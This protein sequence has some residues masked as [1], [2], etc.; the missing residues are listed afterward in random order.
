MGDC[1]GG[2]AA[3]HTHSTHLR[4]PHMFLITGATGNIGSGVVDLLHSH[5][6]PVRALVRDPARA[7]LLPY[8][9]ETAVGDLDDA[10]SLT[11]AL[12]GVDAVFL[13]HAGAGTAQT[14][15][16]IGAA[17]S[18]GVDRVVLLSSIGA[19]LRPTP[20]IGQTLAA[21]E[22]LMRA[23]GLDVTYLRPNTLMS[24][25]LGWAEAVREGKSVVDST[26]PGR[27][28]CVDPE[29]V[30]RVAATAL[31]EDGHSGHG[32]IL[33]GPEALTSAEQVQILS[34]VLG[35]SIDLVDTTPEQMEAEST[36]HGVPAPAA[37]AMRNLNEM[38]RTSRAG[39]LSDDVENLTGT[40]PRT[41]QQWCERHADSFR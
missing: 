8:G 40:P 36:A 3:A 34:E 2:Y 41:F 7:R 27:M 11:A 32:Y 24:N 33:N 31:T 17:R 6:H 1:H 12:G 13:L 28:P 4:G 19:R 22:D 25:T 26:G 30:A 18:A 16:M 20:V 15:N 38:F 5:G 37:A 23:S 10:A 21:R 14:E 39:V 9:I 35:R 29:D